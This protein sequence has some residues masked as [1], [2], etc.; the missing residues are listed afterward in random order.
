MT[1]KSKNKTAKVSR[2]KDIIKIREEINKTEIKKIEKKNQNNKTN[3]WV[4]VR[5]NKINRPLFRLTKKRDNPNK[6]NEK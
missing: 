3:R 5:V 1:T 6:Q 2:S 4:F